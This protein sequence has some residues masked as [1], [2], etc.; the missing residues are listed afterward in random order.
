MSDATNGSK[1]GAPAAR[2]G[3]GGASILLTPREESRIV[4]ALSAARG[5]RPVG[6]EQVSAVL[7]WAYQ[8]ALDAELLA[9]VLSGE[10]LV[11]IDD[12]GRVAFRGASR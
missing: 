4:E 9:L 10:V 8:A 1:T 6:D 12:D 2:E 3:E 5:H 11:D 7:D